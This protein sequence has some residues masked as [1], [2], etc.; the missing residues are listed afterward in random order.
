MKIEIL[1]ANLGIVA[2]II[3][4]HGIP[5]DSGWSIWAFLLCNLGI[6]LVIPAFVSGISKLLT[7]S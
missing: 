4:W 6:M 5:Y 2:I 7:Q 1:L 3:G